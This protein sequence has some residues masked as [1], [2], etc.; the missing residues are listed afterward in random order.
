MHCTT[1]NTTVTHS[2]LNTPQCPFPLLE[3]DLLCKLNA[4]RL[5]IPPENARKAQIRLLTKKSNR[6]EDIPEEV[7]DAVIPLAWA[8]GTPG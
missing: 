5:H 1:R 3:R 6:E 2:L 8:A 7:L 4:V